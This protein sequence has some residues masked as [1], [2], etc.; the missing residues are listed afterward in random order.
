MKKIISLMAVVAFMVVALQTTAQ[1]T[2]GVKAG[3]NMANISQN[4]KVAD[5]EMPTKMG[6]AFHGGLAVDYALSEKMSIQSG[7]LFTIKGYNVDLD[8]WAKELDAEFDVSGIELEGSSTARLNYL[9]IPIH[10]AY[11]INEKLQLFA[12]PYVAIGFGGKAKSDITL[13]FDGQS[14]PLENETVTLKSVIGEA[15]YTDLA[16]EGEDF[17]NGLDFGLNVGLG[18]K[19]TPAILVNAGYSL[20]LG[21]LNPSKIKDYADYEPKDYKMSNNVISLSV[22][23]LFGK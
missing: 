18:Y 8:E 13:K 23:Y 17:V 11:G 4:Y 12:G 5:E 20:G 21:N 16:E 10:F 22:T 19:V 9:E 3:L 2:F 1:I 14:E 7:L 15:D 6:I